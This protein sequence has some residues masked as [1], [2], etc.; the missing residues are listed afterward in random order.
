MRPVLQ[1][2][3]ALQAAGSLAKPISRTGTGFFE[4]WLE[5]KLEAIRRSPSSS[6]LGLRVTRGLGSKGYGKVRISVV[7]PKLKDFQDFNFTYRRQFQYRWTENFLHSSLLDVTPGSHRVSIGGQQVTIDLPAE[8]VGIRGVLISDPCISSKW[9]HCAYADKFQT[10]A[11]TPKMLNA[12]F[13]DD[14]MNFL[15]I[16]GDNFYDQTGEL[17]NVIFSQLSLDVKRRFLMVVNGNHDNW[18]CGSNHCGGPADNYGHGQM[19]YY[20]QDTVASTL[21]PQDDVNFL[22]FAVNPDH[23]KDWHAFQNDATNFLAY[24]KLGNLGFLTFS[25]AGSLR[26]SEPHFQA[27]CDYFARA[28][29]AAVF[30]MGHWN[31]EGLGCEKDMAVPEV[32]EELMKIPSCA[33]FGE[34]LK[35]M[36]GHEHCNYVQT[37]GRTPYGFMI[38]AHGMDD[39]CKP[40]YGFLYADSTN[41]RVSLHYFEVASEEKGDRFDEILGCVQRKGGL[42]A[43]TS[44]AD[45]WLD[46]PIS[47]ARGESTVISV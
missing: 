31:T 8:D 23:R 44:L 11:R 1:V 4:P 9:I 33:A 17:N 3:L 32:R 27:A 43:C 13:A 35:Y 28:K 7:A 24:Q 29:P 39:R 10:P 26:D 16:L 25:G 18:V 46:E 30:L 47:G 12:A 19:Q 15:A 40:Q 38:G 36:D 37:T 6:S 45:T 34:R 21:P 42:H 14:S 41:S 20:A 2:L 22:S 5:Q